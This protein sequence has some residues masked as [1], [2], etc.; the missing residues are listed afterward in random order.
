MDGI[1][2]YR[3]ETSFLYKNRKEF[4][5]RIKSGLIEARKIL[6]N[7]KNQFII[8][9]CFGGAAL[10]ETARSGEEMTGFVSFHG[11]LKYQKDKT[12]LKQL[13]QYSYFMDLLIQCQVWMMLQI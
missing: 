12:I 9:Y 1:E 7:L 13:S 10:L 5:K 8:G 6:G 11:G 3:K 2:D 4:R